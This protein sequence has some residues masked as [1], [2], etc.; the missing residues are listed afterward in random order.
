MADK[1]FPYGRQTIEG[2]DI[3]AVEAV[4]RSDFLTTGPTVE[5]FESEFSL[6]VGARHTVACSSGT[7]ALH[8]AALA[9]QLGPGD[10]VVVPSLTFLATANAARYVG[11]DVSF[12]DV[13]PHTGLMTTES[14]EAALD[15][16]KKLGSPRAVFVVHLNGATANMGALSGVA[17]D[18]NCVVVEDACHAL[19]TDG[20]GRC[21]FS[22]MACFSFHPVKLIAAGEG[23]AITTNDFSLADAL[24]RFRNHGM[25]RDFD[26]LS[27]SSMASDVHGQPNPWYYEMPELGFNYRLSDIHAALVRNQLKKLER[28]LLR[29]RELASIYDEMLGP[30]EDLVQP[31]GYR[32]GPHSAWH[33][34]A[35]LIDFEKTGKSRAQVMSEL[36][37]DGV[38]TQVHYIPVHRQ[39]YYQKLYGY[40]NLPGADRY[41]DRAL[42]L[43]LYPTLKREDIERVVKALE[44][45]LKS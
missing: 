20:V 41:Y 24:M 23:G 29:R 37:A 36:K 34:Y 22:D 6:V 43:P 17:R 25:V 27:A 1:F 3:A 11:A 44:K 28:F 18:Q 14:L 26:K 15:R 16:A 39:P 35:V 38:G 21:E 4:L 2:D 40:I 10:V 30:L 19:G 42:S 9:L 5:L 7:A 12:A 33:L 8:L 31:V 13:D 45:S 32:S